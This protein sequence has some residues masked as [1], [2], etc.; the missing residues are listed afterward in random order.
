MH[1]NSTP[2][3]PSLGDL[4]SIAAENNP[5]K[6]A[7]AEGVDGRSVTWAEFDAASRRAANA[8]REYAT[9]GDRVAF[10]CDA[11]IDHVTLWNG[12]LKAGCIVSNVH[13]RASPETVQYCIDQLRPSVLVV[14][15][16]RSEF[17]ESR[18]YDGLDTDLDAVVTTGEARAAY[19]VSMEEFVADRSETAPSASTSAEQISAVIWTSGT[20]GRPKG[21]CHTGRSLFVKSLKSGTYERTSRLPLLFTP[22]FAAWYTSTVPSLVTNASVFIL[23]EWDPEEYLRTIQECELTNAVLVP[24]MWQEIMRLDSFDEYDVSSLERI[25]A[26]GERL[27]KTTL[28]ALRENVC[29]DVVNTYA[30]TEVNATMITNDELAGDRIESVGKPLPGTRVRVVERGGP[31][32]AQKPPGEVGEIIVKG[33]DCAVWAWNDTAK[34]EDTFEDG[35]WYSGDLGYKDESGYLFLEG[36]ADFMILSKGIKVYP[37]PVEERLNAHPGVEEA[38]VFG[39][40]DAEYGEMVTAVVQANDPSITAADLD[41]WCLAS[42]ELARFERPREYHISSESLPRTASGKLDRRSAKSELDVE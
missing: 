12:A 41:E 18:V 34:T 16:D 37:V 6:V 39:V 9:Q 14:D 33:Q 27:D 32:D 5:S 17:L 10:L 38:A 25:V 8:V 31:P 23:D 2:E 21:W 15:E 3:L 40:E 42:D 19:E 24:T 11:S 28:E 7:F 22:S 30:A 4:S 20:T 29:D 1:T 35:W 36:R 26:S 13:T